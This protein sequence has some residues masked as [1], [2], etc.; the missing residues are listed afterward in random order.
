M[1]DPET[2]PP[3]AAYDRWAPSYARSGRNPLTEAG[4][5]LL[6]DLLPPLAGLDLLDLACGD[7]RWTERAMAAG[8][9]SCVGVDFSAGM[10]QV[11]R[12]RLP[13]S[14]MVAADMHRLPF[15]PSSFDLV[16]LSLAL[17]HAS[18]PALVAEACAKVLR[19]AGRLAILDLH[20]SAARRG[21]TRSFR[22]DA[23]RRQA[24]SWRAW[25]IASVEGLLHSAGLSIEAR[26]EIALEPG[27]LPASAPAA[28]TAGPALYALLASRSARAGPTRLS[29]PR[30]QPGEPE[31][32]PVSDRRFR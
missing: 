2:L 10:L 17:G 14:R 20:P 19:P 22:D 18:R 7:G 12:E 11:A 29:E 8:A 28:A 21:W 16:I 31:G 25:P 30:Q 27:R 26:R 5:R 23:G 6:A 3:R 13:G 15:R 9:R 24:V 4:E 1:A 32:P